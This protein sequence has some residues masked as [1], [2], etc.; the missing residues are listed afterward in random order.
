MSE[1]LKLLV[2]SV[3]GLDSNVNTLEESTL[4]LGS[5]PE[6]DSMAAVSLLIAIEDRFDI[7]LEDDE[8][9]A[10]IF[11]TFGT[12]YKFVSSKLDQK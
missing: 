3:L 2:C 4:L 10:D 12:I 5:I 7:V 8:V 9:S 6:L 1:E 11:Q